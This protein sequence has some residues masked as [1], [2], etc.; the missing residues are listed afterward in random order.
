VESLNI[1]ATCSTVNSGMT[2]SDILW[3]CTP[4]QF[5]EAKT[6]KGCRV[7]MIMQQ[8]W[9][10]NNDQS[11]ERVRDESGKSRMRPASYRSRMDGET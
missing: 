2:D 9:R 1:A 8:P 3:I 11:E 5:W 4:W 6:K 10:V 7:G